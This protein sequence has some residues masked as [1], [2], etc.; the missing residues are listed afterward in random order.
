MQTQRKNILYNSACSRVAKRRNR[1]KTSES[2]K[3]IRGAQLADAEIF[4]RLARASSL[5]DRKFCAMQVAA[6]T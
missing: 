3:V 6:P 4:A 5:S 2:V 1:S